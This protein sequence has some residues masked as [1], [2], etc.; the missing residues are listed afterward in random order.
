M[1]RTPVDSARPRLRD[2]AGAAT[3]TPLFLA[4]LVT[5]ALSG[6]A[7]FGSGVTEHALLDF[8]LLASIVTGAALVLF[9]GLMIWS[10]RGGHRAALI[11]AARPGSVV[12]RAMR[13]RGLRAAV[14]KLKVEVQF[15]PIGLTIVADD[16]GFEVWGGSAE[17]PVRLGRSRWDEVAGIRVAHVAR[18]GRASDGL[19]VSII[20][21]DRVVDLPFAIIGAG[22]GGLFAPPAV[23]IEAAVAALEERRTAFARV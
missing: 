11:G 18:L 9:A 3:P 22:F 7:I 13:A 20:D 14:R 21:G 17:H 19:L 15:V 23:E 8:L 10:T 6:F 2:D 4:Y 5:L 16:S 12:L 1:Q